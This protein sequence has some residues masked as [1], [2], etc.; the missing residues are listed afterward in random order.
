MKRT[1]A[2]LSAPTMASKLAS[3]I[4]LEPAGTKSP[5]PKCEP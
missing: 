1:F 5:R 4:Y 3:F 2:S